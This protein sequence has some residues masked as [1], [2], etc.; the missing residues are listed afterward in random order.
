MNLIKY[1]IKMH[2]WRPLF[3]LYYHHHWEIVCSVYSCFSLY[4]LWVFVDVLLMMI[5][6]MRK[7][8]MQTYDFMQIEM[9][10]IWFGTLPSTHERIIKINR[11]FFNLCTTSINTQLLMIVFGFFFSSFILIFFYG[12][13]NIFDVNSSNAFSILIQVD[14]VVCCIFGS[15]VNAEKS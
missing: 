5:D 4:S 11:N 10:G 3:I 7:M 8:N 14:V 2:I 6:E 15:L 12:K 1:A 13:K 9:K